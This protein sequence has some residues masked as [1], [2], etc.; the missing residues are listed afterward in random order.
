MCCDKGSG[1]RDRIRI[2]GRGTAAR[3]ERAQLLSRSAVPPAGVG[4]DVH[5]AV[6]LAPALPALAG[7]ATTCIETAAPDGADL[8][9]G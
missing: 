5:K 2:A 9:G 7:A 6:P 8:Q 4:G 1:G 3:A